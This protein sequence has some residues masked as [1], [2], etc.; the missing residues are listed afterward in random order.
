MGVEETFRL[1]SEHI[2]ARLD[3]GDI[4]LRCGVP[5]VMYAMLCCH[6]QPGDRRYQGGQGAQWLPL[7][8][9]RAAAEE[10]QLLFLM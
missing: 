10:E 7:L 9:R 4:S 5:S 3:R 8:V 1:L 2:L 6:L